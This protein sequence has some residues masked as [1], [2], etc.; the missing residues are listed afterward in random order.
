M[1]PS[2]LLAAS[3]TLAWPCRAVARVIGFLLLVLT[4]VILY[5]VVGRRFFA[6]GSI[7]LR[8]L[9][10]HLHGAIAILGFGYA[11]IL[12]AHVRIDVFAASLG[13]RTRLWIELVAIFVF[14]IPFMAVL[15]W[16]GTEGAYRAWLRGEGSPGGLGL[17]HRWIIRSAIPL[18]GILTILG[19]LSVALR[20]VHALR[21]EGRLE[22]PW[23]R[24]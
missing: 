24:P 3:D 14:L 16:F 10:W 22:Q 17:P 21:G 1:P 12:N 19:A 20:I 11:Y 18:S 15:I 5:D 6:T 8:E 7:L 4:A 23:E 2:R 13:D 9:S